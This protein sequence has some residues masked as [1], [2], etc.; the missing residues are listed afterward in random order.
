MQIEFRRNVL[1]PNIAIAISGAGAAVAGF[2]LIFVVGWWPEIRARY[3]RGGKAADAA[4]GS[5]ADPGLDG[6]TEQLRALDRTVGW[7]SRGAML[8]FGVFV[9]LMVALFV[10]KSQ[11]YL[12]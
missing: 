10:A 7:G 1:P 6:A 9:L 3:S 2:L 8:L 12:P 5:A 4:I 11:G